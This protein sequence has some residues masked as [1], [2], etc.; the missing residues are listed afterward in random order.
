MKTKIFFDFKNLK[1]EYSQNV[2][3]D[4]YNIKRMPQKS[5]GSGFHSKG[6]VNKLNMHKCWNKIQKWNKSL[7]IYLLIPKKNL[8]DEEPPA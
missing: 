7:Y 4:V 2:E 6:T 1:N 3:K 8:D 5:C